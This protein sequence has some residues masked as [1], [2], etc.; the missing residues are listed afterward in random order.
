MIYLSFI[1]PILEYADVI[2]N[3]CT[4]YEKDDLDKIQNECARIVT[5]CTRLVSLRLLHI[6]SGWE[7]LHTRREKHKLLLF[8]KMKNGLSPDYLSNLV[9]Q[10][11]GQASTRSLRNSSNISSIRTHTS[12]HMNSFI[13]STISLWNSLP[14]EAKTIDTVSGFKTY[15][16]SDNPKQNNLFYYGKRRSQVIHT[17]LRNECSSLNHH[18]FVKNIVPSSLC[19][20]GS[21]ETT[22]HFLLVCPLFIVQRQLMLNSVAALTEVTLRNLLYGDT[23]LTEEQ[24]RAMFDAVHIF[25]QMSKRFDSQ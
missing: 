10:T 7:S 12:L 9:P 19:V 15:L 21:Q 1:R 2:W 23:N 13:P 3:N 25:I 18:L 6:E 4:Q 16:K 8:F 14:V 24:N 5:G 20:C 11:V 22:Y 17:R